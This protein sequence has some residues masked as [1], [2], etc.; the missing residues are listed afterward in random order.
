[1]IL[2]ILGIS[3]ILFVLGFVLYA[4]TNL[5]GTCWLIG[6]IGAV[7][8]IIAL[9]TTLCLGITCVQNST[10]S[11]RMA[12]YQEEN[13]KIEQQIADIVENYQKY[14]SDIFAEV[15]PESAITLIAMYPELKSDSLVE[16]QIGVYVQNNEK[17]KTLREELINAK[18]YRWWLYFGG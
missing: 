16:A 2:V 17:I 1:M 5:D 18:V 7:I 9:I 3:L 4:N 8:G 6:G 12:M 10:V 13:S 14:E 15:T 11:E